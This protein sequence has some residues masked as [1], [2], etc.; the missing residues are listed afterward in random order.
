[1]F[2][3]SVCCR[4][5]RELVLG[6]FHGA[7]H[8]V[9]ENGQVHVSHKNKAPFCHWNLEELASRCFLA[10]IQCVAFEKSNYPGY[11]NKR[12]DGSR[13]DQPFF[14]GKCSTFKFRLCRIAKE[15]YAEKVKWRE[16]KERES[17]CPQAFTYKRPV[18]F[19][20]GYPLQTEFE[21]VSQRAVPFDF[22]YHRDHNFR[23]V[24]DPLVQSRQRRSPLDLYYYQERRCSEFEDARFAL[25]RDHARFQNNSI[26]LD[27]VRYTERSS[28]LRQDFPF[29][30]RQEQSHESSYCL[31]GVALDIYIQRLLKR[32]NFPHLYTG[33]SPDRRHLRCQDFP[34]QANQEPLFGCSNRFNEVSND[35]YNGG[36]RRMLRPASF[37]HPFTGES[38]E[39]ILT[40]QSNFN[41]HPPHH[42]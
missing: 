40:R 17:N 6:F 26:E 31:T 20:H 15:L 36:A 19:D 12:G 21:V 1:M 30:H 14:L 42:W 13:C 28:L 24:H 3:L 11:E 27:K 10:L 5:H 34:V 23:Q 4:K 29:H 8:L 16:V 39:R 25:E 41:I 2:S 22:S 37:S 9:N 7:S 35:I 32:T 33:E 18:S 38:Q